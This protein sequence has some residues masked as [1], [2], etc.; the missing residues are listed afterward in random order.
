ML[1]LKIAAWAVAIIAILGGVGYV[2]TLFRSR[3]E[4]PREEPEKAQ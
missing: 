2:Y 3:R 1:L 4:P